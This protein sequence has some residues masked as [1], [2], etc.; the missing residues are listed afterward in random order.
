V[1]LLRKNRI[2]R[3]LVLGA[4]ATASLAS[5]WSSH[6][7]LG[8]PVVQPPG[9]ANVAAGG[10]T[11]ALMANAN[12]WR[13]RGEPAAALKE[14]ERVLAYAPRNPD[15]IAAAAEVSLELGDA[16]SADTYRAML[17]VVA[18]DDPRNQDLAA[19]HE[20]T[21]KDKALL[22]DARQ[23]AANGKNE[24]AL[25]R[26]DE[27]FQG[28]IP[29]SLAIEYYSTL[30]LSSPK[31]YDDGLQHLQDLA[32]REPDNLLLQLARAK[33]LALQE[34][35]RNEAIRSLA[36]LAKHPDIERTARENWRQVLLWQG[37]SEKARAQIQN[38]LKTYPG[39]PT[40]EAKLRS[41][42]QTLPS[43]SVLAVMHGYIDVENDPAKAEQEFREALRTDPNNTHALTMLAARLR[44]TG[45]PAEAEIYLDRALAAAPDQREALLAAAGGLRE[46]VLPLN[47]REKVQVTILA[48]SGNYMEA[49][50][51]LTRLYRGREQAA[52]YI[53]LGNIQLHAGEFDAAEKSFRRAVTMAP[54]SGEAACGLATALVRLGEFDDQFYQ[55]RGLV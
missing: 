34:D 35:G 3:L 16:K 43:Q 9:A 15:V 32:D 30:A 45:R 7:A 36:E 51:L 11:P 12:Y 37:P 5:A 49:E 6:A 44:A 48:N 27:V 14:L 18:P 10:V 26:Y 25:A 1:K 50:Q 24:A 28:K 38:Y 17:S 33:V 47:S 29:A 22:D 13:S 39:D 41:F 53:Q 23:L 31:G 8:Q 2:K 55:G 20:R 4:Y 52:S 54:R 19:E 21:P 42:D 40:L 46:G